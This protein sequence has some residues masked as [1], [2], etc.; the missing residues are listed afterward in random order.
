MLPQVK[1]VYVRL[2]E[3]ISG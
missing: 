3:V 2:D 1:S